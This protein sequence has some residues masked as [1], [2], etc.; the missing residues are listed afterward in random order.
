MNWRTGRVTAIVRAIWIGA[1]A[2]SAAGCASVELNLPGLSKGEDVASLADTRQRANL[3]AALGQLE[4]QPWSP[5]DYQEQQ[6]ED[7]LMGLIFGSGG[8]SA[9]SQAEQYLASL[10]GNPVLQVQNDLERTLSAV[11]NVV[12]V[13]RDAVSSMQPM[14]SD[15][16]TLEDAIIEARR[17]RLVYAETLTMLSREDTSVSREDVRFVKERFNEAIL[18]LGRTADAMSLRLEQD[19]KSGGVALSQLA[20]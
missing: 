6:D 16:V 1:L 13:G 2:L 7:G 10:G 17:C 18:E 12:Y 5:T 20:L 3:E 15:L 11:W 8:P 14:A 19:V 4:N 9:R